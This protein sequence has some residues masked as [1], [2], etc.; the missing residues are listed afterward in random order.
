MTNIIS[1][2]ELHLASIIAREVR[3]DEEIAILQL[4]KM[5]NWGKLS[6]RDEFLLNYLIYNKDNYITPLLTTY[7]KNSRIRDY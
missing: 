2:D 4:K 7:A 1:F 3:V 6:W 5:D